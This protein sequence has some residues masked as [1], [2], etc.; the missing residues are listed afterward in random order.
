VI[1][2]ARTGRDRRRSTAVTNTDQ[3]NSGI[4]SNSI[5]RARRLAT[6]LMKLIAPNKELTPAKCREKMAKSTAQPACPEFALRGG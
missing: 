4:R 5:P 3:L 6:V 2:P 1:A